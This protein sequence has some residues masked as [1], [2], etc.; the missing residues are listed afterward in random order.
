M[1]KIVCIMLGGVFVGYLLRNKKLGWVS[2]CILVA[3]WILLFLLGIA[4]GNN[5]DI[6][7][8]LD[9]IGFEAL[10]ISTGAVGG[11]VVLAWVVYRFIYKVKSE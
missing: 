8:H 5:N 3:I 7:N 6:L 1:L 11:S 10:I 4:V 2:G 9:T